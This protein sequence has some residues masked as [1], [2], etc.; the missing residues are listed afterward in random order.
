M[1]PLPAPYQALRLLQERVDGECSAARLCRLMQDAIDDG[2]VT[3]PMI[4][5][6]GRI[7][8]GNPTSSAAAQ[9][10][11]ALLSECGFLDLIENVPGP[12]SHVLQPRIWLDFLQSRYP[13]MFRRCLGA[14]ESRLQEFWGTFRKHPQFADHI[15]RHSFLSTF[16]DW[17][18][19]IPLSLHEDAGP[20]T[21]RLSVVCVSFAGVLRTGPEKQT[22]FLICSYIKPECRQPAGDVDAIWAPIL[23]N[24]SLLRE[25]HGGWRYILLFLKADLE[26]RAVSWGLPSYNGHEPCTECRANRTL[27]PFTDLRPTAAWVP[28]VLADATDYYGRARSPLHPVLASE[29]AWLGFTP[30][31]AMHAWG[32][33]GTTSI[34]AGSV[35]SSLVSNERR[36]GTNREARLAAINAELSEVYEHRPSCSRMPPLRIGDLRTHEWANLTGP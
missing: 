17:G 14:D 7:A 4:R 10:L 2:Q 13:A 3:H 1:R 31:D 5:R 27:R 25:Q 34:V 11:V 28:T 22:Q 8:A 20:Y 9:S 15:R 26:T 6:L 24:F 12:V 21:K 33:N 32:C 35:V 18:H 29:F 30:L 16:S 19:L 36:L 23:Q